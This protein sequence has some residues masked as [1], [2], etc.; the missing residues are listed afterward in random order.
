MKIVRM[1]TSSFWK[2]EAGVKGLVE[3]QGE[4]YEVNLYLGGDR[5]RD[6]SCSCSKGNSYKGM[7]AHEEALFAYYK[8]QKAESAKPAVHTSTQVHT[9][10]REYTNRE[11]ARIM[12]EEVDAQVRLEPVLLLDGREVRLEF[13]AGITRFYAIRDLSAFK[14]AVENGTYVEYG[15]DLAFHH[16]KSAFASDSR[17]LLSLLLGVA[18][19]QM[20]V[21]DLA[22]SRMNRD[23][24]FSMVTGRELE[25]QLPGG[26]RGRLKMEDSDPVLVIRVEKAGRDGLKVTLQ[27]LALVNGSEEPKRMS[28]CFRGEH[29]LYAAAGQR[30]FRCGEECTQVAGLFLEQISGERDGSVLVGQRDIPLFYERVIKYI[31]PYS[32]LLLKDVDFKDYEPEPLRASFRFDGG[33]DGS[34][35]MEP[36]L[37]YG[38]C[39]FHPLEDENLPRTICRDVPGEFRVSQLIHKY[40]KYKD[41]DGRRVVIKEN[42]DEIYRLLTEGMDEFRSMGQVYLS[43]KLRNWKVLAPPRV[44]VGASA[45]SGWL[46]LDIDMGDMNSQELT[47]IL[48]AYSQK[49]KYYRLKNGQFLGLDEGGLTILSRLASDMGVTGKEL[50]T[51]KVR[52]PAY[53]AFYLDYLLKESFGVTYH[54][55]QML[56]AMVRAVKSVEDADYAVPESLKDVLREYQRVGY[57][58]LKTLDSY[59]FGGILAD[60]MGLGKTIQV[61]A[62]LEDAYQTGEQSPSLIV[63]PASLVYNWEHEIVRFAP[64]LKVLSIVGSSAEREEALAGI[65]E[66]SCGYQVLV[67]SYDLLKRDIG[68]YEGI[69]LRYQVIDE[70]QYIKNAATQS[71]KAVKALDVQTRFA[72]TGTPVENRLGELWSIFD[73]LMPG[74][75]FGVQYFKREYEIPIAKDG[76]Q[77][78]LGRLKRMIGP[79]VLRRVKKD[80]LRELPD[81]LEEVV[82]SNFE[83]EQKKLYT[84]NAARFKEKLD[85]GGFG[86]GGEGKLQILA[87]LMRLRQLCCDPRLCYDNY[88]SGSAKLETCMDLVRRGVAG[89]HK[90]LLF[91]Q[92]TSM[93]ELVRERFE[94]EGIKSHVL[95][96]ATSKEERIRLVGD[97]GKDD[98]PVFLISL[99]AGGTGLNLTAADIVIHYDPWW[100]VA[101]QNQATDRTHR[102]GQDKQVTVYKLITRNTIEENIL[103]LQEA[104]SRLA[105]TVVSEGTVSFASLTQDDILNIIKEEE[106]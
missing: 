65:R 92:F 59:G 96:G 62:L 63:C 57:V 100:N 87:E 22:L 86:P 95:T 58:W 12:A 49:K 94:K 97:F 47:R 6:Y 88:K 31:L 38:S 74:F 91:S 68:S 64:D 40:F 104:K 89:G 11:V 17:E 56:K 66:A 4:T 50:Q 23:R 48:A 19:N 30:L 35:L 45:V 16:N 90:I 93:L 72:L 54:R 70:A 77:E 80:V 13:K 24:F 41:P 106:E 37:A 1:N 28:A 82:Y 67:T 105:D 21:R 8:Q 18:E 81:K 26:V 25:V 52:L 61:I 101:A 75:L 53:R 79:F 76:D 102:I 34:L 78:A 3:D 43:E 51:G 9:M 20:A 14:N 7:C 55:D 29:Y 85:T 83:P 15:R 84:A 27:G 60:D 99:K 10:I 73:Y 39:V 5:V 46:E 71:A 33:V 2:G 98:V 32:R 103:K 36:S 69:H 42:E 44:S